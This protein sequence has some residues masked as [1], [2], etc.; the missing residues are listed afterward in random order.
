LIEKLKP[1]TKSA[2]PLAYFAQDCKPLGH[3]LT[4]DWFA[5][6]LLHEKLGLQALQ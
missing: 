6:G 4:A 3:C 2:Q 5:R 1:I